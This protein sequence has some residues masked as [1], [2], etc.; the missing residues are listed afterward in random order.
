[1]EGV[2]HETWTIT[3]YA[4]FTRNAPYANSGH[5]QTSLMQFF[6]KKFDCRSVI[7]VAVPKYVLGLHD[8]KSTAQ[9]MKFSIKDFFS[10]CDQIRSFLKI[11][12]HLPKKSLMENIIFEQSYFLRTFRFSKSFSLFGKLFLWGFPKIFTAEVFVLPMIYNI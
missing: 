12:P 2:I 3:F 9:K 4:F 10:K 1:M 5:N 6:R 11:W 8:L 7:I